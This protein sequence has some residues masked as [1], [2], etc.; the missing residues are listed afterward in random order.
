MLFIYLSIYVHM[1]DS[2]EMIA[3]KNQL[4]ESL[5][6]GLNIYIYIY[7]YMYTYVYIYIYIHIHIHVYI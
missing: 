4:A 7:I 5:L 3:L 6:S 1:N 2:E